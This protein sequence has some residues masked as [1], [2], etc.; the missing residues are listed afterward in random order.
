[1]TKIP[2]LL[3]ALTLLVC[4]GSLTS[5][6]H[7]RYLLPSHTVLSGES[8]QAVGFQASISNDMFHADRPLGDNGSGKVSPS[9]KGF[10]STIQPTILLPDG[11]AVQ[12]PF[13]QAFARFSAGDFI[14]QESGTY[15]FSLPQPNLIMT[16]FKNADGT[17]GRRFGTQ[18]DIPEGVSD[19]KTTKIYSR[20]ETFVTLN[21]PTRN[22][23]EPEGAGLELS[24]KSHPNDLFVGETLHFQLFFD[25]KPLNAPCE[26]TVVQGATRHR[27][28]RNDQMLKT[29]ADGQFQVSFPHA[30]YYLVKADLDLPGEPGSGI[31][32]HSASLFV[33]LEVFPE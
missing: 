24:G 10:F 14:L 26:V 6:A 1:M 13:V 27:N 11:K 20:V 17:G 21:K 29:A 12:H 22:A 30:G 31:D 16:T 33:T 9:L 2:R 23:W 18:P 4:F 25:G 8:G 5:L 15:R 7:D 19:V 32:A 3:P 28:A